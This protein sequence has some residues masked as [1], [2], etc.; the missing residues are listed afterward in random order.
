MLIFKMLDLLL[1]GYDTHIVFILCVFHLGVV[2]AHLRLEFF[3]VFAGVVVEVVNHVLLNL[4]HVTLDLSFVKL[5]FQVLDGH[6]KLRAEHSHVV[7][8]W[9]NLG[10]GSLLALLSLSFFAFSSH[11]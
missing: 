4:E 10:L 2:V 8:F 5:F 6:F 7:V 3:D 1:V 9:L 11:I